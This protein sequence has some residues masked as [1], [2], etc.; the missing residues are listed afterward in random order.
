MKINEKFR[1]KQHQKQQIYRYFYF[2]I[3]ENI[4]GPFFQEKT[5]EH[6]HGKTVATLKTGQNCVIFLNLWYFRALSK[7]VSS[8]IFKV[9]SIT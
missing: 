3:N 8:K 5:G 1:N 4:T 2:E 7:A 9:K 6:D